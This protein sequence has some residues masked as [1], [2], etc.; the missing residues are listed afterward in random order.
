[1][2]GKRKAPSKKHASFRRYIPQSQLSLPGFETGFTQDLDKGNRWVKLS[3]K[4]PWDEVVRIYYLHH[5]RKSTGRPGLSPRILIG[6][7][8]IKHLND[9]GDGETI[10]QIRE[11]VY[12]QYF[13]G[14]EEFTTEAPFDSS[15]FVD[16]RKKLTHSLLASINERLCAI[17]QQGLLPKSVAELDQKDD[18]SEDTKS[19]KSEK[20]ATCVKNEDSLE[21][22]KTPTDKEAMEVSAKVTHKGELLMDASVAPQGIAYPTD[23]NLLNDARM[24]SE[25][26]IDSLFARIKRELKDLIIELK[27]IEHP[28]AIFASS[29][30]GDLEISW[31]KE[32]I[33]SL[34]RI[35]KPRTYR[36]LA[37]KAYLKV[38]QSKRPSKKKI[39]SA[40]G[41]Q[42]RYLRRN[43]KHIDNL[44]N[45]FDSE[46]F[47]L[48]HSLQRYYWVIQ[49]LYVQQKEMFDEK[50]HKV[51]NRIVSIHQPHVRPIVRGKAKANTEFGAKIHLSLIDGY[52][53]LDTISWE[54]FNEGTHL[55]D[56]VENY[57]Q[58]FGY[59]PEKVLVDKIYCTRANRKWLKDKQIKLAAKPLG[60]PSAK[61]V[62]NHVSPGERNPIEGKFGQAKLR[63]GMNRIR[64]KLQNTSESWISSIILVLNLV[65]LTRQALYCLVIASFSN[66]AMPFWTFFSLQTRKQMERPNYMRI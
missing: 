56:Y 22:V 58:R 8:I 65:N 26:I 49:L 48:D 39:R 11:N 13:L 52:S 50:K 63:Y 17:N 54:A 24:T 47:P 3:K 64:A 46:R 27:V 30:N 32:R 33:I 55:T 31:R 7:V 15:V 2:Q 5:P 35:K 62:E 42:I 20:Q 25:L 66:G 9:Y 53:F 6:S 28:D 12:L 57:K 10:E 44:L 38:A 19:D 60:R 23:L 36:Q 14:F 34:K 45:S 61:A 51:D 37:R 4:I 1:M 41:K 43:F 59:Y 29:L 40:V 16:I 21:S 18:L